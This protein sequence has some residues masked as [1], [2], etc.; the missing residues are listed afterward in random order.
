MRLDRRPRTDSDPNNFLRPTRMGGEQ[1]ARCGKSGR[2]RTARLQREGN[3]IRTPKYDI[4]VVKDKVTIRDRQSGAYVEA[5]GDPHLWTGDGDK[6]M[7][8]A[9][10]LTLDLPDGTKLTIEPTAVQN[11]VSWVE[12]LHVMNG[13]HALSVDAI[14]S[15]A[16]PR[17]GEL[18]FDAADVD[19]AIEDGIVLYTDGSIDDLFSRE[20]G[21]ELS[22]TNGE[23]LLDGMRGASGIEVWNREVEPVLASTKGLD[24]YTRLF[25]VMSKLQKALESKVDQLEEIGKLRAE[26]KNS[27]KHKGRDFD[28]EI[29]KLQ[30]EIQ[31]LSQMMQ[32]FSQLM[33][34]LS[35]NDHE[36]KMGIA[37]NLR[38]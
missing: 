11:G 23:R 30:F 6:F 10:N 19:A 3:V 18:G 12:K 2:S 7:F 9:D 5:W 29:Q 22:H 36:M 17:F 35:K 21:L 27:S 20:T 34:N 16:E 31:Q 13:D 24:I 25:L 4:T 28:T 37:R 33:T 32:Q 26:Q 14:H 8:T 15:G 38:S 1:L